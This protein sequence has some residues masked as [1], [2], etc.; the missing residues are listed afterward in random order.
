M[1]MS[2]L[3]YVGATMAM[4]PVKASEINPERSTPATYADACHAMEWICRTHGLI[5]RMV[6]PSGRNNSW[7]S[8]ARAHALSMAEF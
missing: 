8:F 1:R 7:P 3:A 2:S 4:H 6:Y 5:K